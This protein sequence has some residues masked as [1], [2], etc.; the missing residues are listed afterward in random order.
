[1]E[2]TSEL[3][4]RGWALYCDRKDKDWSLVDCISFVVMRENQMDTP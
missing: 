1:M 4:Q 2:L 3:S